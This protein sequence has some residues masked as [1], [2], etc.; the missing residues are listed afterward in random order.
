MPIWARCKRD[1]EGS[2]SPTGWDK[3]IEI[4]KRIRFSSSFV[5]D[6]ASKKAA[7]WLRRRSCYPLGVSKVA[8]GLL[9][10][11]GSIMCNSGGFAR[12]EAESSPRDTE[13]PN[14]RTKATV[15]VRI[16]RD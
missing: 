13:F 9:S 14:D 1:G 12:K 8:F 2:E 15:G 11:M 4:S 7:Q 10:R 6:D 3:R 5:Q 16:P